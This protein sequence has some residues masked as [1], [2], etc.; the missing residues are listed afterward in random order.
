MPASILPR[1]PFGRMLTA[2]VTPFTARGELDVDQAQR[3][4][5]HLADHGHDGL[6]VV[7]TTGEAPTVSESEQATLLRAVVEAVGDR[8][9]VVAGVGTNDTQHSVELARQAEKCAVDGLLV[10]APYYNKPPQEGITAHFT[11]VADATGMPVILYDIPGRTGVRIAAETFARVAEHDRI[12]AVKDA[13]GD[14]FAGSWVMQRTGLAYYSGD[15]TLNLAWLTGGAVGVVSVVGHVAG[16]DYASMIRAVDNSDLATALSVHR[17]L[18]P[19]V[20][21]IMHR[22]QGA[23]MVKAA[24]QLQGVLAERTVRLPLIEATED[25]IGRLRPDLV[26]A[27][28]LEDATA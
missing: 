23:I 11:A 15:D 8:V 18:L 7:G 25:Q 10:V 1:A 17:R 13:V 21:A 22:T 24:L 20:E 2:M 27:G 9:S 6:V 14:L 26:S 3:L 12:V 5:V 28:L 4:A 19:A 16:E